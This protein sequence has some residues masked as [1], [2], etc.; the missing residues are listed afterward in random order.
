MCLHMG[1]FWSSDS[2]VEGRCPVDSLYSYVMM[3]RGSGASPQKC[4]EPN[5]SIGK[6]HLLDR[7]ARN[8]NELEERVQYEG[9]FLLPVPHGR[10]QRD[11]YPSCTPK[12]RFLQK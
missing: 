8:R 11:S 10:G 6:C 3:T 12:H 4:L 2:L 9:H 5:C 1:R 7:S